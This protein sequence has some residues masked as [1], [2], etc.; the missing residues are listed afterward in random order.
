M[1]AAQCISCLRCRRVRLCVTVTMV[2]MPADRRP[3]ACSD[4]SASIVLY[5]MP[6]TAPYQHIHINTVRNE[7]WE[8][9]WTRSNNKY[10]TIAS[11]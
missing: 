8:R 7:Q 9:K 1:A 2:A 11:P 4:I 6:V 3:P 10:D 5:V